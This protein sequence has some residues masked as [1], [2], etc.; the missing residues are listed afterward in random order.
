MNWQIVITK[1]RAASDQHARDA[2]VADQKGWLSIAQ[3]HHI[4]SEVCYA[5]MAA[6]EAGANR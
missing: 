1:L 6:L 3:K 2:E 5:L 4:V